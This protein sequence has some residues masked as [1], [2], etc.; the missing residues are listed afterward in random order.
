MNNNMKDFIAEPSW[1]MEH[2]DDPDLII[3][4]SPWDEYSYGRAHIPGAISRPGHSYVK[5]MDSDGNPTLHV[6]DEAEIME[7]IKKLG[8]RQNST[9]VVYDEWGTKFAAR[10][11]WVLRYYG[12]NGCKVLNGGWQGWLA[13]G[14]PVT[15]VP[16]EAHI[17]MSDFIPMQ[18]PDRIITLAELKTKFNSPDVQILDVRSEDEYSGKDF[19]GNLRCGHLPGAIHL[20]WDTL[21]TNPGDNGG[22]QRFRSEDEMR[23]LLDE[24]GVSKEKTIITHC[25]A[26][27]R[28]AFMAITLE[29]L[30]Y[31][32]PRLYDGSMAEWANLEDTP[33]EIESD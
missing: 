8:I 27:I 29:M 31:P 5:G 18:Q 23:I 4:D 33:L 12:F 10:L 20:K 7:L 25:Q 17:D 24:A 11:C 16:S 1:L 26:A 19:D 3:V 14:Y 13:E 30:G 2:K 32:I 22:V 9:L 28:A 6:S 15:N 21:L